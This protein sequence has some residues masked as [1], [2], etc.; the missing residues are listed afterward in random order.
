V[1]PEPFW[2]G[3]LFPSV[4]F[5]VLY[6]WPWLEQRFIT[7]DLSRHE[8]LD[9]P[10]DNPRRTAIGAAFFAWVVTVFAAG[11]ADRIFLSVGV[12]Y[13]TQVWLFRAA[14]FVVPAVVYFVARRWVAPP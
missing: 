14:I 7:R 5:G 4:V 13:D 6:L 8:L 10:R 9:A 1:I 2:G 12:P 11:A 3:V